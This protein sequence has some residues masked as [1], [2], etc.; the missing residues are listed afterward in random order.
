MPRR[1]DRYLVRLYRWSG[2]RAEQEMSLDP[3]SDADLMAALRRMAE[4][5]R[6]TPRLSKYDYAEYAIDV[7]DAGGGQSL[8]ARCAG[9][10]RVRR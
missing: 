4:D 10:G 3:G 1:A 5:D 6:G 7:H 2:L 9:N 8:R